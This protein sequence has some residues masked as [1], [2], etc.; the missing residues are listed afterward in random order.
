MSS[1]DNETTSPD[2]A[3]NDHSVTVLPTLAAATATTTSTA[4][5][6]AAAFIGSEE[7]Q[8]V[9]VTE[10]QLKWAQF[11]Y[12]KRAQQV[13]EAVE[14]LWQTPASVTD[15]EGALSDD[16][17]TTEDDSTSSVTPPG[18]N[19][20]DDDDESEKE[21]K[22]LKAVLDRRKERDVVAGRNARKPTISRGRR[23]MLRVS[24]RAYAERQEEIQMYG[25]RC[26][27]TGNDFCSDG[28]VDDDDDDKA[29]EALAAQYADETAWK[30][31]R[32]NRR[33]SRRRKVN[34]KF[35]SATAADDDDDNDDNDDRLR[36]FENA[37][38]AMLMSLAAS[39]QPQHP[40]IEAPTKVWSRPEDAPAMMSI[41]GRQYQDLKWGVS[42]NHEKVGQ[43]NVTT[44][45]P[46]D[47]GASW[48]V[49][50]PPKQ[51]THQDY[52]ALMASRF[53]TNAAG[54]FLVPEN[55][56][57]GQ[58][59]R[60]V[61]VAL[62]SEKFHEIVETLQQQATLSQQQK[63]AEKAE[64]SKKST[65]GNFQWQSSSPPG[66]R[67]KAHKDQSNDQQDQLDP[68]Q[69]RTIA[70]QYLSEFV[71]NA[72]EEHLIAALG[73]KYR[74]DVETL[75]GAAL[76]GGGNQGVPD[77]SSSQTSDS[78][79]VV[80]HYLKDLKS[81]RSE[82]NFDATKSESDS[83]D[84]EDEER[85]S[86]HR[87]QMASFAGIAARYLTE[88]ARQKPIKRTVITCRREQAIAVDKMKAFL[89]NLEME[90][91]NVED[92]GS[93]QM[94]DRDLQGRLE[95]IIANFIH[96]NTKVE[97]NVA[98]IVAEL[99]RRE[100]KDF[101]KVIT[102][103]L[104][105]VK[106]SLVKKNRK[107][108][109]P[110]AGTKSVSTGNT[111]NRY[112][113]SLE[114]GDATCETNAGQGNTIVAQEKSITA[115]Q[116]LFEE[117][118]LDYIA[119]LC[120]ADQQEEQ[121]QGP[122]IVAEL[123][124]GN[125]NNFSCFVNEYLQA[126]DSTIEL[127]G[128]KTD[129]PVTGGL[130]SP[131]KRSRAKQNIF[132]KSQPIF[133]ELGHATEKE[134]NNQKIFEAVASRYLANCSARNLAN[135][136][137]CDENTIFAELGR[138][139]R[140]GFSRIMT[141]YLEEAMMPEKAPCNMAVTRYLENAQSSFVGYSASAAATRI[142]GSSAIDSI[143][144]Q[145]MTIAF[146][147]FSVEEIKTPL[148][149]EVGISI[150]KAAAAFLASV[151]DCVAA[152]KQKFVLDG[153][154]NQGA[155][156]SF[157]NSHS[158]SLVPD[159]DA[160]VSVLDFKGPTVESKQDSESLSNHSVT[161]STLE[162]YK[163][164]RRSAASKS[165]SAATFPSDGRNSGGIASRYLSTVADD[166]DEDD[167][168]AELR[169]QESPRFLVGS[170]PQTQKVEKEE[171]EENIACKYASPMHSHILSHLSKL[172]TDCDDVHILATIG[173]LGER[174]QDRFHFAD[175]VSRLLLGVNNSTIS[176]RLAS[177]TKSSRAS[178]SRH[179]AF[180]RG[181]DVEPENSPAISCFE[182]AVVERAAA[183]LV[184]ASASAQSNHEIF[185]AS[186]KKLG[187]QE[188]ES[189]A[190]L[191]S[192]YLSGS[193]ALSLMPS[194]EYTSN[195]IESDVRN[196]TYSPRVLK[197]TID[198]KSNKRELFRDDFNEE[199]K[200]PEG[201][202]PAQ[203]AEIL[204]ALPMTPDAENTPLEGPPEGFPDCD[205]QECH[206]P[207]RSTFSKS[208]LCR[209]HL[210]S[211]IS[212]ETLRDFHKNVRDQSA[213]IGDGEAEQTIIDTD[214]TTSEAGNSA[215]GPRNVAGLMLSPTILTKRHRQAILA[216]EN[217]K[218]DQ[219]SYLLN[220]NPW[221]AEMPE[222]RTSQYLLHKLSKYGV[223]D[224]LNPSAPEQ[225]CNDLVKMY[226]AAQKF[227]R[228]GNLPLHMACTSGNMKMIAI[229]GERFPGGASVRNEEGMLPLHLAIA[230][231]A[232][233]RRGEESLVD[234]VRAVLAYFPGALA[235]AD[236]AGNLPL[237]V[238][239]GCLEDDAVDVINLLLDEAER[240]LDN[241]IGIRFRNKMKAEDT[242]NAS[243]SSATVAT[244]DVPDGVDEDND[245]LPPSMVLND[246]GDTP[247]LVAI[248]R[249][250][251]PEIV[252]A[253]SVG[254]GG[255]KAAVKPDLNNISPLHLLLQQYRPSSAAI[256]SILKTAP[257]AAL[258]YNSDRMLPVEV[259]KIAKVKCA[260]LKEC[261][262]KCIQKI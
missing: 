173:S 146:S 98:T 23:A 125:G 233:S 160:G 56:S 228:D 226:A 110:S 3:A 191:I 243:M 215:M 91:A 210:S 185:S 227:D 154:Q 86:I 128:P 21:R 239:A 137:R 69:L 112:M 16:G 147:D 55:N 202:S 166:C 77:A 167:I 51:Q 229:L 96:C 15:V 122:D 127:L 204:R 126:F 75:M 157:L 30:K 103:Y 124:E 134:I 50:I 245:K 155:V 87:D 196:Q 258:E 49:H 130:V 46:M 170:L 172:R 104:T 82:D 13:R 141:R 246:A 19:S 35:R 101:S 53:P 242:E 262:A 102:K 36:R 161:S 225:L 219:I 180:M 61:P 74:D 199:K 181:E 145:Y 218:W 121:L 222:I 257:E 217:K 26:S 111:A 58:Q 66:T 176:A 205:I 118:A 213:L 31:A 17:N 85:K 190:K 162:I 149:S 256:Q 7:H 163:D 113:T 78:Q 97:T 60:L 28:G 207:S 206:S 203:S 193:F 187:K 6:A 184:M 25:F 236:N 11:H 41:D 148:E 174:N 132:A 235:V 116:R 119:E 255:R 62:G 252:E 135:A 20:N 153:R 93:P 4:A 188:S 211:E 109:V 259:G 195:G 71:A 164:Y 231:S 24:K 194:A 142:V 114:K 230:S 44:D 260:A 177:G 67:T 39:Q 76:D 168:F 198:S 43:V 223:G 63:S 1:I 197:S 18:S 261:K 136:S 100:G 138:D 220:A 99:Q 68:D 105:N 254:P 208:S 108:H 45:F 183:L 201:T 54:E 241:P 169:K 64:Q 106:R 2:P 179:L 33:K 29:G 248:K 178:A 72:D 38:R 90:S 129:T 131:E 250:A 234:V 47:R 224:S 123:R 95:S 34:K 73:E 133:A 253:L 212:P 159:N 80:R 89:D 12:H 48:L 232:S 65:A 83:D 221:L 120:F 156:Q 42:T 107:C 5:A 84:D 144:R 209:P 214:D 237:H 88:L 70:T 27:D 9:V 189:F 151:S 182:S 59:E 150:V 117:F 10:G 200:M 37:F 92:D 244:T 140:Q 171:S 14:H 216:I 32:R 175:G 57:H 186:M 94:L 249:N 22:Q 143:I 238:A 165:R 158:D 247:F 152:N 8:K 240:Q 192:D 52:T 115:G 251:G 40:E 79:E 81:R 139:E